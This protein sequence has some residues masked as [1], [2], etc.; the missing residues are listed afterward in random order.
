MDARLLELTSK[1]DLHF[2]T[3]LDVKDFFERE[4]GFSPPM[5]YVDFIRYSNGATGKIGDKGW[6]E[7]WTLEYIKENHATAQVEE[8]VPGLVMF[9]SNGGGEA[10]GFDV[11]QR[12]IQ[13]VQMP[14]IYDWEDAIPCGHSFLE[15]VES[16]ARGVC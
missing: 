14:F 3:E 2:G 10:Y 7:L 15:F 12:P 16:V 11:R 1:M 13:I 8:Y 4:F 6:L 5:D 9:G